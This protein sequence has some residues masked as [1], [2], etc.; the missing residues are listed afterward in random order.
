M[1][2]LRKK[3]ADDAINLETARFRLRQFNLAS[4]TLRAAIEFVADRPMV[5]IPV[6]YRGTRR[7]PRKPAIH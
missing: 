3:R 6:R 1:R 5:A 4:R 2:S 7:A